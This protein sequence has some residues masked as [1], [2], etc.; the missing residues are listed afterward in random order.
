MSDSIS[1]PDYI[2]PLSGYKGLQL[3]L[4]VAQTDHDL[5]LGAFPTV[6]YRLVS[7][8]MHTELGLLEDSRPIW[9]PHKPFSASCLSPTSKGK[10]PD[11][12]SPHEGCK[13]GIYIT[14]QPHKARGYLGSRILAEIDFWGKCLEFKDGWRVEHTEIKKL[15]LHHKASSKEKAWAQ[16]VAKQ[17][18]ADYNVPVE[19]C[20]L[21]RWEYSKALPG[22]FIKLHLLQ[23]N[24]LIRLFLMV[25]L[26]PV[27]LVAGLFLITQHFDLP[28]WGQIA[29]VTP[30]ALVALLWIY[31][32][33]EMVFLHNWRLYKRGG[34]PPNMPPG[35]LL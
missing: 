33:I 11:H 23:I 8:Q 1:I 14:R 32:L 20:Q 12:K 16:R 27:G 7:P 29:I 9:H 10:D 28:T 31:I 6:R 21:S 24:Q 34:P 35:F 4:C 5:L 2:E 22:S 17:L 13:C 30:V 25:F 3:K 26:L 18:A 15:T 19:T